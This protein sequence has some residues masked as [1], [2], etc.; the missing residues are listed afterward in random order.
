MPTPNSDKIIDKKKA[1]KLVLVI[2]VG[3]CLIFGLRRMNDLK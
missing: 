1:T 2:T 3:A